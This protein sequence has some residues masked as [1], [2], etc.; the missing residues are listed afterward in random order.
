MPQVVFIMRIQVAVPD[1]QGI[2]G[3]DRRVPFNPTAAAPR[4][5]GNAGS[6]A[7]NVLAEMLAGTFAQRCFHAANEINK[8]LVAFGQ[9]GDLGPPVAHLEVDVVVVI[10]CPGGMYPVVP[11]ALQRH[12]QVA[13]L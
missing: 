3:V 12:R 1:M 4:V 5:L 7:A 6:P 2:P 11:D 13:G 10:A 9:V 8:R